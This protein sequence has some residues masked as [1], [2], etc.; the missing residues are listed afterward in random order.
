MA[1][2]FADVPGHRFAYDVDGTVV[3]S[4][5]QAGAWQTLTAADL[6]ITNDESEADWLAWCTGST[7]VGSSGVYLNTADDRTAGTSYLT[8]VFPQ[9]RNLTGY[10]VRAEVLAGNQYYLPNQ[11]AVSSDTTDGTDGSWTQLLNPW[12]Y[13]SSLIVPRFRDAIQPV[14]GG[15]NIKA[16]RFAVNKAGAA[17]DGNDRTR[18]FALH[19]YGTLVGS[20]NGIRFW[21]ATL[22]QEMDKSNFDYGDIAQSTMVTRTFRLKNTSSQTANTVVVSAESP[23]TGTIAALAAGMTFSTDNSSYATTATVTSIAPG[24]ISPVLYARRTVGAAETASARA[25]RIKAVPGSWS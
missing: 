24:A 23:D 22:D 5:G 16:V 19:L 10:F 4:R 1:G 7:W 17:V 18:L 21:N 15:D 9:L 11:L 13:S 14:T 25:A 12:I 2:I 8:L 3:R 20:N 6:S